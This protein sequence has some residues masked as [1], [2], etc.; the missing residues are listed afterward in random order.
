MDPGWRGGAEFPT[1]GSARPPAL[2]PAPRWRWRSI[3]I[4]IINLFAKNQNIHNNHRL[5]MMAGRQ[6]N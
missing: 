2:P 3:I 1:G 6:K 5:Y 4:I